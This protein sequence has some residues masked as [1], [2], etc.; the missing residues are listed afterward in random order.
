MIKIV[1]LA[2]GS[3]KRLR[4]NLPKALVDLGNGKTILDLQLAN[5]ETCFDIDNIVLVVGYKKEMIME[6]FSNLAFVYNKD[7]DIT[8]TGK[9]LLFGLKKL[10]GNDVL[11]INGDVVFEPDIIKKI[12]EHSEE[13]IICVNRARVSAEEVKYTVNAGGYI[14]AISKEVKNPVGE[15]IGINFIKHQHLDLLIRE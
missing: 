9:S 5:L 12:L 4:F 3:G 14:S 7:F 6:R 10:K 8:N 11:W 13:N 2:A 1:I 15:A